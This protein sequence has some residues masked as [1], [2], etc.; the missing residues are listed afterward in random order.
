MEDNSDHQ[1][2]KHANITQIRAAATTPN[3]TTK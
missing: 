1:E 3:T 2:S